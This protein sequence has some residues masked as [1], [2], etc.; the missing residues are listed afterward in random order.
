MSCNVPHH[1]LQHY[2]ASSFYLLGTHLGE[3]NA[4]IPLAPKV[5]EQ[6]RT[7][8]SSKITADPMVLPK[9]MYKLIKARCAAGMYDDA[10]CP[11]FKQVE[12]YI[13]YMRSRDSR[14]KSTV[15]SV[16]TELE[17]WRLND[18]IGEQ[19]PNKAFVFG[20]PYMGGEFQLGD[21]GLACFRLGSTAV[22]LMAKYRRV[23]ASN[24]GRVVL[25]HMDTTFSTNLSGFL[26]LFSPFMHLHY[27]NAHTRR[28]CM[29]AE[30]AQ[31]DIHAS[32]EFQLD[33]K[34]NHR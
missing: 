19:D 24:P 1:D 10:L 25:C 33:S 7:D 8:I 18:N 11:T 31:G 28:R 30:G 34:Q 16:R 26:W 12:N 2:I 9:A 27:I 22:A 32:A 29:A 20:V 21:G 17:K 6:M 15:P 23:V 4:A 13:Q 5:T 3:G 14:L